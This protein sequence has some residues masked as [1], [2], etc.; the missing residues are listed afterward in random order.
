MT[1]RRYIPFLFV[2]VL[3]VPRALFAQAVEPP[4]LVTDRPDFTESSDVIDAGGFQ[5]E[6]GASFESDGA[7]ADRARSF[8]AP[9]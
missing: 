9:P 8:T 4:P 1:N 3:L 5:F 7:G 6:S 2:A